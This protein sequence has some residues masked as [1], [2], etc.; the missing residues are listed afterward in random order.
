[1]IVKTAFRI[2]GIACL[3]AMLASCDELDLT[4][5]NDTDPDPDP[6]PKPEYVEAMAGSWE[7]T[8][9]MFTSNADPSLSFDAVQLG[10]HMWLVL[11]KDGA[12]E[13]TFVHGPE[14][15]E[16]EV[17]TI[18]ATE[19]SVTATVP[20]QEPMV[21]EYTLEDNVL[22]LVN[23]NEE[24]DFHDTGEYE[25][26]TLTI[27]LEPAQPTSE[28]SELVGLWTAEAFVATELGVPDQHLDLVDFGAFVTMEVKADGTL[29]VV[30]G[31]PG[32][33]EQ[34]F[35]S[36]TISVDGW[37]LKLDFP[38]EPEVVVSYSLSE[39]ALSISQV[40]PWDFGEGYVLARIDQVFVPIDEPPSLED[41]QGV[42]VLDE[43]TI[44]NPYDH[45]QSVTVPAADMGMYMTLVIDGTEAKM[46]EIFF[47]EEPHADDPPLQ[48]SVFGNLAVLEHYSGDRFAA[49]FT[50]ED[51]VLTLMISEEAEFDWSGDGQDELALVHMHFVP[52]DGPTVD[53]LVGIWTA[54]SIV[55]EHPEL[56]G[57]EVDMLD[58]GGVFTIEVEAGGQTTSIMQP[59]ARVHREIDSS[60]L[61]SYGPVLIS[62]IEDEYGQ[63]EVIYQLF[64]LEGDQLIIVDP[65]D[66]YPWDGE[67]YPEDVAIMTATLRPVTDVA[68]AADLEGTWEVTQ[69]IF[70]EIGGA[71]RIEDGLEPGE[72][73]Y[74]IVGS[75]LSFVM[76]TVEE[77]QDPVQQ[78]AGYIEVFGN[79]LMVF[80]PPELDNPSDTPPDGWAQ[81]YELTDTELRLWIYNAASDFDGTESVPAII[82]QVLVKVPG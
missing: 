18:T 19:T 3:A 39:G 75:D 30:L 35:S 21:L 12:Y 62:I 37:L 28:L 69:M 31:F 73:G 55:W 54:E 6:D 7:A 15:V 33:E 78:A 17:G 25:P 63:E 80:F 66:S 51:G 22:T 14:G 64:F 71:G 72:T 48:I 29:D 58:N 56:P 13:A 46:I 2:L 67:E 36:G 5:P 43:A 34:Q 11:E 60:Q 74:L 59:A 82:E 70:R 8:S 47:G 9:F 41:L 16:V 77:G 53:D 44:T 40:Q 4:D 27:V 26:A 61:V 57:R 50:L 76:Q 24:A 81:R 10:M 79:I 45:E 52:Y 68:T 42:R 49:P 65:Y 23:P 32:D 38:G 20:G 1:M